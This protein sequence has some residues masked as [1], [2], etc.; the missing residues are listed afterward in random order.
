MKYVY[1]LR[2]LSSSDRY[3]VGCTADLKKRVSQ[4]NNGESIHTNK[5]MPWDLIEYFA[6]SDPVKADKFESYLKTASGRSFAKKHF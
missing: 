5:F 6:F 3:Y 1:I 4:H 2:S